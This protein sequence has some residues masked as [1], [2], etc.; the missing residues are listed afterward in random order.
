[1]IAPASAGPI[2]VLISNV[3]L[4][5]VTALVYWSRGTRTGSSDARAGRANASA[6][7]L[8]STTGLMIQLL[9]EPCSASA[10]SNAGQTTSTTCVTVS[11]FFR[12][13]R[14]ATCPASGESS[15]T[16]I[17]CIKLSTAR[18]SAD[19]VNSVS[20]PVCFTPDSCTAHATAVVSACDPITARK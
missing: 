15:S 11:S 6:M 7:P 17:A 1:M 4:F 12:L 20:L 13:N 16:G 8:I 19:A 5:H 2:T 3:V 10:A 9:S 14:S 18:R